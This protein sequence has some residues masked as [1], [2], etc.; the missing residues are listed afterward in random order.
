MEYYEMDTVDQVRDCVSFMQDNGYTH[1]FVDYWYA[2]TM[3]EVSNGTLNVGGMTE[4]EGGQ[5]H[6]KRWGTSKSVFEP[7]NMP[8]KVVVFIHREKAAD[9]E[10]L[11][12]ALP[13]VH[14]GWIFNGYEADSGLIQ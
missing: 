2:S 14:E 11:F 1:G 3:M 12:P 8:Q 6:L 9:F 13:L 7:A 5:I 4:P 10:A